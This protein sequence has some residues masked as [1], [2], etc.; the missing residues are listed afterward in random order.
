VVPNPDAARAVQ[1]INPSLTTRGDAAHTAFVPSLSCK[2]VCVSS[3]CL[4]EFKNTSKIGIP[5]GRMLA[6]TVTPDSAKQEYTL[7]LP[8]PLAPGEAWRTLAVF[9]QIDSCKAYVK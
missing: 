8:K 7:S 5:E 1:Q 6:F 4:P 9:D 2:G 3:G